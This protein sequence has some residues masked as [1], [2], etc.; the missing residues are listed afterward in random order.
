MADVEIDIAGE[1]AGWSGMLSEKRAGFESA[2]GRGN[3][4]RRNQALCRDRR[5]R[6]EHNLT[7]STAR[8]FFR[9][10]TLVGLR[11]AVDGPLLLGR[12]NRTIAVTRSL[13]LRLAE[14]RL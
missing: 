1:D 2:R 12:D 6:R 8:R 5:R 14:F 3:G 4:R 10:W 13:V 9:G 7:G 11:V